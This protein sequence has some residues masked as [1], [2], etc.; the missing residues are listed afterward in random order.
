[1]N[2]LTKVC[3]LNICVFLAPS[4]LADFIS[5]STGKL[6][7]K[8]FYFN[9]DYREP[10]ATQ[11][12][13]EEWAQGFAL[14][15]ESG[16]TEGTVGVGVDVLAMAGFKL[17]SSADRTRSG[18]LP[19]RQSGKAEDS[20]GEAA[21]T[22][23]FRASQTTLK[24]GALAPPALPILEKNVGR[25]QPQLFKGAHLRSQ[26][27]KDLTLDV[28]RITHVNQVDS[29]N[30]EALAVA[31]GAR[32]NI[33]VRGKN[34]SNAFDFAGGSYA[35]NK[36]LTASYYYS[37]LDNLYTQHAGSLQHTYP[38]A[39]D[40]SLKSELRYTRS[41]DNGQT[42]IDNTAV[43]AMLTYAWG[44]HK[45]G[46]AYQTMSGNTGHAAVR[47]SYPTLVNFLQYSDFANKDEKSWQVRYD[48]DFTALGVPGLSMFTRYA[49]GSNVDR[50]P[51]RSDGREW[52]RDI[53]VSYAF[54]NPTLKNV[55]VRLRNA[56]MRSNFE[57]D[58]DETRL[59]VSYE[60]PLW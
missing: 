25:L 6:E 55:K 50:G 4:A 46:G 37:T 28:G 38:V 56:M 45:L 30:Y 39:E 17:D 60:K 26:E 12:K 53:D 34:Q 58:I 31:T 21:F 52:E 27:L 32:R 57:S 22:A 47:G 59:I 16:Y 42:N 15:I 51:G 3:V 24:I 2:V 20:Y 10:N 1:M 48:Y 40:Q 29:T 23:K 49:S 33:V 43:G 19:V 14:Q 5:D 18:L 54:Q 11:S 7:L 36:Q 35:V 41:L 8:N 13:R 9:R 44:A